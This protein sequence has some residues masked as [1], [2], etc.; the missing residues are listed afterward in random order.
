MDTL[1]FAAGLITGVGIMIYAHR[2]E[3]NAVDC[4][5]RRGEKAHTTDEAYIG[6]IKRELTSVNHQ[7]D[8]YR[9]RLD[10]DRAYRDGYHAGRRDP[11]NDAEQLID[12]FNGRQMKIV[13]RTKEA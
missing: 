3:A 10:M 12:S 7:R 2:R 5:R 6:A 11:L 1:I 8:D 4:E 13:N 9:A